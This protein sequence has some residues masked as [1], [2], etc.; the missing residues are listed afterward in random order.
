MGKELFLHSHCRREQ[1]A[2]VYSIFWPGTDKWPEDDDMAGVSPACISY[3]G[4]PIQLNLVF[5]S[6]ELVVLWSALA[7]ARHEGGSL[8]H[9]A[10]HTTRET[11]SSALVT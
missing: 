6:G 7:W 3:C 11:P 1:L 4:C 2:T 9:P 8:P 10:S 5:H